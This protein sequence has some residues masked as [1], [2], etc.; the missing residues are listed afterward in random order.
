MMNVQ[1]LIHGVV[2]IQATMLMPENSNAV[3]FDIETESGTL[4]QTLYFGNGVKEASDAAAL[5]YFLGGA[6]ENVVGL[7]EHT[8]RFE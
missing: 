8:A 4:A 6:T 7:S 2:K 3:S 1:Q 5:F